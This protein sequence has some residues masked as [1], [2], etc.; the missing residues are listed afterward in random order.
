MAATVA[1]LVVGSSSATVG[2]TVAG[3]DGGR[4]RGVDAERGGILRGDVSVAA[5]LGVMPPSIIIG[6]A[7]VGVDGAVAL[8]AGR[9]GVPPT[10]ADDDELATAMSAVCSASLGSRCMRCDSRNALPVDAREPVCCG[11][12]KQTRW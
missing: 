1:A 2:D 6:T 11:A 5:R 7:N 10:P 4:R 3:D 12:P 8:V 9:V